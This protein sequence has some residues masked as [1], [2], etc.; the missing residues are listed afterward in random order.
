MERKRGHRYWDRTVTV[1][2]DKNK[3]ILRLQIVMREGKQIADSPGQ[4]NGGREQRKYESE[5]NR[6]RSEAAYT[7]SDTELLTAKTR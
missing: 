7:Y 4:S 2:K 5:G 1:T 3:L 6:I